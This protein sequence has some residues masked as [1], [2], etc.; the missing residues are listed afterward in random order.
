MYAACM[1]PVCCLVLYTLMN[2][3]IQPVTQFNEA[4]VPPWSQ[5]SRVEEVSFSAAAGHVTFGYIT[6]LVKAPALKRFRLGRMSNTTTCAL[7]Y[8]TQVSATLQQIYIANADSY[9]DELNEAFQKHWQVF[10]EEV[11]V[12]EITLKRLPPSTWQQGLLC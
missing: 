5:M 4:R 10:T 7:I 1:Y 2:S 8:L 11:H 9:G 12:T 3:L 6:A